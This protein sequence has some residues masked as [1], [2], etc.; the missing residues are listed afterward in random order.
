[1]M[2]DGVVNLRYSLYQRHSIEAITSNRGF[3][4]T[5]PDQHLT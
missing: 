1:M 3:E 2:Y 4:S 5:N